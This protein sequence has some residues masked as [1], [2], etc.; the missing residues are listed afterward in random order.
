M[1]SHGDISLE[2]YLGDLEAAFIDFEEQYGNPDLR[3][4]VICLKDDI[5][6]IER[7]DENSLPLTDGERTEMMREMLTDV[8]LLDARGYIVIPF[9]TRLDDLCPLT[10]N[11]KIH[12][13]EAQLLGSDLG[14]TVARLYLGQRGTGTVRGVDGEKSFY[15]FPD[16]V[17]VLNAI[18]GE[19]RVFDGNIF[20]GDVYKNRRLRDMPMLNTGWELVINQRDEK[21]NQDVNLQSLDDICLYIYYT[22]FTELL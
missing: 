2:S 10:R 16:R 20:D 19:Q 7:Y 13:I 4:E 18:V 6:N 14:D 9:A 11:H 1:V 17:A 8:S 12:H 3:V 21:A 5:F 22:D 15:R